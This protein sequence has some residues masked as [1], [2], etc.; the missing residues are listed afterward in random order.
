MPVSSPTGVAVKAPDEAQRIAEPIS[1]GGG[2]KKRQVCGSVQGTFVLSIAPFRRMLV[3]GTGIL[4][5][6]CFLT[7][8]MPRRTM[9]TESMMKEMK[10][11]GACRLPGESRNANRKGAVI[12]MNTCVVTMRSV[13]YAMK[14][15]QL[16]RNYAIDARPVR[17][18]AQTVAKGCAYGLE[19]SCMQAD[20]VASIFVKNGIPYSGIA[21]RG[22]VL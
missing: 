21:E 20:A 1:A 16:L 6:M 17:L 10:G 14:G 8:G 5:R 4:L 19:I 18:N 2:G 13:T 3:L 9:Q 7:A 11:K 12:R 15:Q 22:A